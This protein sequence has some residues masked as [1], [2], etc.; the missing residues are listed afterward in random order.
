MSEIGATLP[1]PGLRSNICTRLLK[2]ISEVRNFPHTHPVFNP[3]SHTTPLLNASVARGDT[4][5]AFNVPMR[6]I[7]AESVQE[8]PWMQAFSASVSIGPLK[9]CAEFPKPR[10]SVRTVRFIPEAEYLGGMTEA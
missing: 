7:S 5:R 1:T 8:K 10:A 4:K 9:K 6:F 3:V 2:L